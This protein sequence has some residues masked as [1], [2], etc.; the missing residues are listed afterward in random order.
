MRLNLIHGLAGAA[1]AVAAYGFVAWQA[2][3]PARADL[4]WHEGELVRFEEVVRHDRQ[5]RRWLLLR[6]DG[7]ARTFRHDRGRPAFDALREGVAEGA[8]VAVLYDPNDDGETA[9][10]WSVRRGERVLF[11]Y[12][13][14]AAWDRRN[15]TWGLWVGIAMVVVGGFLGVLAT[16]VELRES[17]DQASS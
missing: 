13:D 1:L 4:R 10:A 14:M 5:S 12:A 11:D 17:P 16:V 7:L 3:P 15:R 8:D 6:L 2:D 9:R